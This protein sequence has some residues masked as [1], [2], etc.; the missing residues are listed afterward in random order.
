M[1]LLN[2]DR[3]SKVPLFRQVFSQLKDLI[4]GNTLKPGYRMPST[5]ELAEK[6][7]VNRSTVYKAYEELWALGYTESRPGSYSVVRKRHKT[8][9]DMGRA[10]KGLI[11]WEKKS[12]EAGRFIYHTFGKM[13]SGLPERPAAELI[14]LASL[15]IDHRLFPLDDFKRSINT[16]LVEQGG[17][18]FKYGECGGY[19]P[20]REYVSGRMRIH[21]IMVEPEEILIT[22]GS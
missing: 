7:G 16:V 21:G 3:E 8:L 15:D 13:K 14:N 20:L 9:S 18:M 10:K 19:R 11:P 12:S 22:N 17:E 6:H 2:L 4:D 1:I 5:R